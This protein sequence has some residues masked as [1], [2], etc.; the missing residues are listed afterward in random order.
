PHKKVL[1]VTNV[2]KGVVP[3]GIPYMA[4]SLGKPEDNIMPTGMLE[5]NGI[6]VLVAEVEQ[7]KRQEKLLVA[8]KEC[9]IAYDKLVL[10][11]GARPVLPKIEGIAK[12]GIFLIQKELTALKE[13]FAYLKQSEEIVV[14]GGGFIGIELADELSKLPGKKISLVELLP[15]LLANSFDAEFGALAEKKLKEKGVRILTGTKV[16]GFEGGS[17]VTGIKLADGTVL[18]AAA[19]V[20]AIGA[21]P[22]GALA[23]AVGLETGKGGGICVDE[24]MRTSDPDIFA[25]GDCAEKR[26]FY[27]RKSVSVMLASTAT[28]EARIAG[29]NLFGLKVVRE[30]KGTIAAYSTCIDGLV[31]ASAGLTEEAAKKEGFEIVIGTAE[32]VDKH[33]AAMPGSAPLKV[34]LIFSRHS[35]IILGGQAAGGISCGEIIN[36]IGLAIQTRMS[37]SELETLQIATHPWLTSAPTTYP[38]VA[39]AQ[40]AAVKMNSGV[41]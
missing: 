28:A 35:G 5:K 27:T 21:V 22:N 14:I 16:A 26:D 7:I 32:G 6:E 11:T 8:D 19:V 39:A 40:N 30:N 15:C 36:S 9:G 20:L 41:I 37:F 29:S 12:E 1:L 13:M 25:I 24:Y 10:A 31:L 4:A 18:P 3:C 23:A 2:E 38:L 34:K 33:P 17:R